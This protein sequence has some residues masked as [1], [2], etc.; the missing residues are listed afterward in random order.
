M[1][2][3]IITTHKLSFQH[4]KECHL[5]KF[6]WIRNRPPDKTDRPFS[7]LIL[8]LQTVAQ[9]TSAKPLKEVVGTA[10]KREQN[11]RDVGLSIVSLPFEWP[12]NLPLVQ[13]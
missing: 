4:G 1:K 10:R 2:E 3:Y 5:V 7:S 6:S 9:E 12:A 11:F 13:A 8:A